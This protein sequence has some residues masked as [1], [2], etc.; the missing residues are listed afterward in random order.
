[1]VSTAR[2][3]V[4]VNL[5][6]DRYYNLVQH[7][8]P[9]ES[10]A[11]F[12]L[13]FLRPFAVPRMA[14]LLL[15]AGNVTADAELRAYRTGLQ[16]YEVIAGRL[17]SPRARTVLSHIN[18]A[19]AAHHISEE[20]FNYVLDAFIVVPLRHIENYGWRRPTALER[21]ATVEFYRALGSRMAIRDLPATY[22]DVAERFDTY[23][24]ANVGQSV[25]TLQLG[26]LTLE[27]LRR[28]LP[29]PVKPYASQLFSAQLHDARVA[30]ALGLPSP[31]SALQGALQPVLRAQGAL[32]AF[33]HRNRPFF[34]AGQPA[35]PFPSGYSLPDIL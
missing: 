7:A 31:S 3:D 15:R 25:S 14:D 2:G 1:M 5:I 23:E 22:A 13:A 10:F 6:A 26:K 29:S 27:V 17:D 9:A 24:A 11:A 33:K 32:V 35:R 8:M 18:R 4:H 30:D 20:D 21:H 12:Q 28:R 19:H 34:T 16:M